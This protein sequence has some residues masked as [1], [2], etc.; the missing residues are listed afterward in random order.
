MENL[1]L[2]YLKELYLYQNQIE[3]INGLIGCPR[4][5]R[6]WLNQ[7]HIKH[8]YNIS[9][10]PELEELHLQSNHIHSLHGI[11]LN[12][13]LISLHLAGNP[14]DDFTELSYL[15]PLKELT[16]LSLQDIHYG[17]CPLVDD[18]NYR[19]YIYCYMKQ[20]ILLDGIT[21][22]NSKIETAEDN[23]LTQV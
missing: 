9:N 16:E 19:N 11:E 12:I 7:N 3:E 13:N 10:V 1:D 8:I 15:F 6:L 17:R 23:F 22:S 2:P 21:V 4:L 5:K 18:P 20:V 14:L